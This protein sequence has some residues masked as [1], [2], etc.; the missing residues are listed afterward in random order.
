VRKSMK[1]NVFFVSEVRDDSIFRGTGLRTG[2]ILLSINGKVCPD[3]L[4]DVLSTIGSIGGLVQLTVARTKPS[5]EIEDRD[6][7]KGQVNSRRLRVFEATRRKKSEKLGFTID[8]GRF[9]NPDGS[10]QLVVTRVHPNGTFPDLKR[11]S[12]LRSI[13]GKPCTDYK[14]AV[15]VLRSSKTIRI[16]VEEPARPTLANGP[17]QRSVMLGRREIKIETPPRGVVLIWSLIAAEL[18]FDLVT[19]GIAFAAFFSD[20][21]VCCEEDI[22][23]NF[24]PLATS[25]PFAFLVIVEL[26]FLLRAIRITLWPPNMTEE[27]L[28]PN[29]SCF[30]KLFFGSNPG[31]VVAIINLLT[32]VNPFF[33]FF[34]AWMLIYQSSEQE[35]YLVIGMECVSIILH[36]I[37]VHYEG[38]A[39]TFLSKLMH[40]L[41]IVPFVAS[42]V[43]LSWYLQVQ[44]ICYNS[45]LDLFWFD[46]CEV[47]PNG[48]PPEDGLCPTTSLVNGVNQTVYREYFLWELKQNTT[49]DDKLGLRMCFFPAE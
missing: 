2:N 37:S 27:E 22:E 43:L 36:F 13:N 39:R 29:R 48:L 28:D 20:P 31:I 5:F 34:I 14:K 12:V 6:E 21:R 26:G 8:V 40:S 10:N 46:G 41:V 23:N 11:G 17:R 9:K 19:T 24:S 32:I 15:K 4:Q 38:Q 49:C 16:E 30:S 35:A 33:G 45:E 25:I 1:C 3:N 47:C 7:E 18:L 42:G 44:G